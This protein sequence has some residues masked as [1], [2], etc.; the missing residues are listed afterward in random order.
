MILG[1]FRSSTAAANVVV[2]YQWS[3][4]FLCLIKEKQS[5]F[6][7][8]DVFATVMIAPCVHTAHTS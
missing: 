6:T 3:F 2:R 8:V 7:A 1:R 5:S 4:V